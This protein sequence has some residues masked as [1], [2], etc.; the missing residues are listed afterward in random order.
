MM[1]LDIY[2]GDESLESFH[3]NFAIVLQILIG[4]HL[5]GIFLDS[6]R[7][8]RKTWTAMINGKNIL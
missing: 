2:W 1:G 4:I 8:K 5:L 3:S 6:I 7:Y